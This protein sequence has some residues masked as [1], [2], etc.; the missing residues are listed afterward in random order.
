MRQNTAE[1]LLFGSEMAG[2][3]ISEFFD[4]FAEVCIMFGPVDVL[5]F[6]ILEFVLIFVDFFVVFE[7]GLVFES[8]DEFVFE[9]LETVCDFEFA[10]GLG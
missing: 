7:E 2:S 1:T 6:L 5:E 4:F 9:L 10:F 8:E 3:D